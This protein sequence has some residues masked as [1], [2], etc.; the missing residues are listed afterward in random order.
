MRNIIIKVCLLLVLFCCKAIILPAQTDTSGIR[1]NWEIINI[2][3]PSGRIEVSIFQIADPKCFIG[4]VWNFN[5]NN[6]GTLKLNASGC[7]SFD[8]EIEWNIDKDE[9]FVLKIG[10]VKSKTVLT[11]YVL[12]IA[13]QTTDSFELTDFVEVSGE[14][15][16]I[17]YQF[18]K[19]FEFR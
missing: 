13:N 11:N 15:K 14:K 1:G 2:L 17:I 3:S 18:E 6:K 16:E 4:S 12:K 19:V 8:S 10:N 5:A 9:N 7:P